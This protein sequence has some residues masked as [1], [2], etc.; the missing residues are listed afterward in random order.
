M[1]N[2]RKLTRTLI[3]LI[4]IVCFSCTETK[5]NRDLFNESL[6]KNIKAGITPLI[7]KGVDSV[8]AQNYISC[9]LETM[10][11]IDSTYFLKDINEQKE[12]YLKNEDKF[13][14]CTLDL[15]SVSANDSLLKA[16]LLNSILNK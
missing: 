15:V 16:R 8:A 14:K 6:E 5:T 3:I 12:I 10:Y 9:I 7:D 13:Q 4:S 11:Q 2:T 1:K